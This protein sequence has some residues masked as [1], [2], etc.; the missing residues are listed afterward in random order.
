MGTSSTPPVARDE[1]SRDHGP[2]QSSV[3]TDLVISD[4][5][6]MTY[7]EYRRREADDRDPMIEVDR[8]ETALTLER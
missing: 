3:G 4:G 1:A 5:E 6:V 7:A 8:R 2:D